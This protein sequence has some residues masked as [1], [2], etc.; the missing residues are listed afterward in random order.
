MFL[1]RYESSDCR[2][3]EN[4][5]GVRFR[6]RDGRI[7]GV[8]DIHRIDLPEQG[9]AR[10]MHWTEHT[11]AFLSEDGRQWSYRAHVFPEAFFP[12]EDTAC[13]RV[14][15]LWDRLPKVGP[16]LAPMAQSMGDIIVVPGE[17]PISASTYWTIRLRCPPGSHGLGIQL[18]AHADSKDLF[19]PIGIWEYT[20]PFER[21]WWLP[22]SRIT[23][24]GI[25]LQAEP[26]CDIV[27]TP[28]NEGSTRLYE[29]WGLKPCPITVTDQD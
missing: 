3:L 15:S 11:L 4:R 20:L 7:T 19:R 8:Y 14:E 16:V 2:E 25:V 23:D 9:V 21:F 13:V 24:D 29:E 26:Y 27:Q 1:V 17:R 22:A 6:L 10:N 28:Q 5:D 12:E 18:G